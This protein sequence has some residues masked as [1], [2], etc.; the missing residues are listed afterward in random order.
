MLFSRYCSL[1]TLEVTKTRKK[2]VSEKGTK[3]KGILNNFLTSLDKLIQ[4]NADSAPRRHENLT[5]QCVIIIL[6]LEHVNTLL[7]EY[8]LTLTC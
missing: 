6:I 8:A 7:N 1:Q 2:R 5:Q 4:I 3:R